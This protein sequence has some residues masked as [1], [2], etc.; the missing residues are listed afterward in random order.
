MQQAL[1]KLTAAAVIFSTLLS[2]C[3]SKEKSIGLG[4]ASGAAAGVSLG[5]IMDP[6]K[7]G[8]Y[9]TRNMIVGGALGTMGGMLAGSLIHDGIDSEKRKAF[10]KGKA[11]G[12]TETI[13]PGDAPELAQP[14][15]ERRWIDPKVL[16]NRYID[17]HYEYVITDPAKW[18][19]Q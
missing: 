9:R 2:S 17:G 11:S 19:S 15:V 10:E 16:G 7:N 5:A 8:E 14:K 6:G 1:S 4:A 3:A 12:K 18:E 13:N